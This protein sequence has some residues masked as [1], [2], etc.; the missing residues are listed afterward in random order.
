MRGQH[1]LVLAANRA[2]PENQAELVPGPDPDKKK[3]Q[4]L[5]ST[6]KVDGFKLNTAYFEAVVKVFQ[7]R[8]FDPKSMKSLNVLTR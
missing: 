6:S 2:E 1:E 7:M 5:F 4:N 8:H 3:L